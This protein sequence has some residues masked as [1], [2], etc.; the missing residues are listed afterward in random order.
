MKINIEIEVDDDFQ[1]CT[2][3]CERECPFGHIDY[4]DDDYCCVH[5]YTNNGYDWTCPVKEAMKEG[6]KDEQD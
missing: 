6:D 3:G 4:D 2:Y 1:P 5:L